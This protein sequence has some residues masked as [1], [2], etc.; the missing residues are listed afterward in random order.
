MAQ[1][2]WLCANRS[3][4]LSQCNGFFAEQSIFRYFRYFS[5]EIGLFQSTFGKDK[6]MRPHVNM[7]TIVRVLMTAIGYWG[8]CGTWIRDKWKLKIDRSVKTPWQEYGVVAGSKWGAPGANGWFRMRSEPF[9]FLSL[10]SLFAFIV[11]IL[12]RVSKR[13][14]YMASVCSRYNARSDWL[15]AASRQ[16]IID[17]II[18]L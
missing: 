11:Q 16:G 3:P 1:E 10:F 5:R 8:S 4:W 2:L 18:L 12:S 13:Y 9:A 17:P 14:Y 6:T 7:S 15:S